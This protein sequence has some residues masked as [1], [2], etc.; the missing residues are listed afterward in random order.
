MQRARVNSSSLRSVGYDPERRVLEV[1]FSNG[2]L[3][4][5]EGVPGEIVREL[6]AADS[7][8]TYFNQVFK[9]SGFPYRRLQ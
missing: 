8:G 2:S 5:Y 9:A 7:L 1:E 4:Q 6:L 3:Y